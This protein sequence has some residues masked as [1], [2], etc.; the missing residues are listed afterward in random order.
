MWYNGSV[1]LHDVKVMWSA[2]PATSFFF[3]R[4]VRKREAETGVFCGFRHQRL[5]RT[6]GRTW[7]NQIDPCDSMDRR[8]GERSERKRHHKSKSV[9]HQQALCQTQFRLLEVLGYLHNSWERSIS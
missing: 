3:M 2:V 7:A 6:L 9:V 1:I 8:L 4:V 5:S